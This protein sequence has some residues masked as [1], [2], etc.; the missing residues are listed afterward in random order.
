[1]ADPTAERRKSPARNSNEK[2]AQQHDGDPASPCSCLGRPAVSISVCFRVYQK[3]YVLEMLFCLC[4]HL[5]H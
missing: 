1:M 4:T 2:T 5:T 3:W